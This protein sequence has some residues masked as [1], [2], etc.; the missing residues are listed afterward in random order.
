MEEVG[1]GEGGA[2][3]GLS[4]FGRH[5]ELVKVVKKIKVVRVVKVVKVAKTFKENEPGSSM[6]E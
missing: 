5:L 6:R 4:K 3:Q 1:E 2:Q